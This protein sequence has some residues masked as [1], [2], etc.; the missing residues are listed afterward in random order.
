MSQHYR[1][2]L[3]AIDEKC[4]PISPAHEIAHLEIRKQ[5]YPHRDEAAPA[6]ILVLPLS[7]HVARF[8]ERH[9]LLVALAL[10]FLGF[11]LG[12]L[13]ESFRP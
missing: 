13:T 5:C 12:G 7:E 3:N 4:K 6:H 1:D 9:A 8:I 10:F 2:M 11:L